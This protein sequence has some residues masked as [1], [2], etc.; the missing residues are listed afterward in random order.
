MPAMPQLVTLPATATNDEIM[1]VINRDGA[2]IIKE[3]MSAKEAADTLAELRPYVDATNDG[4]DA[5]SGFKTT[6]TGALMARSAKCRELVQH[7]KIRAIAD[8]VLL[9]S[10]QRYHIHVTQVIRI[11]PG[12]PAQPI[13]RDR[14]AWVHL[15]GV[16]PQLNTIWALSPFTKENGATNVVPG[17]TDWPDTRQAKPEEIAYAEMSP[18]S[19]IVYTGSV[20][21]G[22]G[23][24]VATDDRIGLYLC[25]SL[26]WLRQEENQ[27]LSCPPE[28][29]RTLDTEVQKLLGYTL[30]SYALGYYTPPLPPGEGP[31]VVPPEYAM[32]QAT[33]ANAMGSQEL[34]AGVVAHIR[35]KS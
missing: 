27:Y 15:K 28:I 8:S 18:G 11:K 21:H 10:C 4:S 22:G 32:G 30:G 3:L 6:R 13:H 25:Y 1:A 14:W 35:S 7:P 19:V 12:Q 33:G 5:F 26:G 34:G 29:A 24:N 17:S 20:F 2:V 23:A 9:P 31:E 16:E